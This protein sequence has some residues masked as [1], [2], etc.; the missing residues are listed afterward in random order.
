[1]IVMC[2]GISRAS[3]GSNRSWISRMRAVSDGWNG[4]MT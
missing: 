1:M 4:A 3:F 2:G